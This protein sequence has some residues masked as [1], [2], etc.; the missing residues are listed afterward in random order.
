MEA[1]TKEPT[2]GFSIFNR[3]IY[4]GFLLAGMGYLISKDFSMA[5][6]FLGLGLVFDPFDTKMPFP[7]RP[8]YQK[9]W[10]I[11]HLFIT[12]SLLVLTLIQH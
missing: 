11:L 12:L 1:E 2:S 3:I 7:R 10:L 4:A 5:L 8:F 9:A 6:S